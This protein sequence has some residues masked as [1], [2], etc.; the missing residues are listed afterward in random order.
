MTLNSGFKMRD[1]FTLIIETLVTKPFNTG[2]VWCR[3]RWAAIE[4]GAGVSASSKMPPS[5]HE[6]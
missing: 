1:K 6:W 4:G 3:G 5:V 2:N